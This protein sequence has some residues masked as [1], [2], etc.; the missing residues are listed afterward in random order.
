MDGSA[1]HGT[2][3]QETAISHQKTIITLVVLSRTVPQPYQCF[4]FCSRNEGRLVILPPQG[5]YFRRCM[6]QRVGTN[7]LFGC[8]GWRICSYDQS[9]PIFH[10][11]KIKWTN[12]PVAA[13]MT[14]SQRKLKTLKENTTLQV[15]FFIVPAIGSVS[16]DNTTKNT[17]NVA[18]INIKHGSYDYLYL[19]GVA[20]S[21]EK[22]ISTRLCTSPLFYGTLYQVPAHCFA[23]PA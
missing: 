21:D 23:F 22:K 12:L 19:K 20:C 6:Y 11:V 2:L 4:C 15:F 8:S 10:L 17:L 5:H 14:E 16:Y 13:L 9:R 18:L 3:K 1:K 7:S